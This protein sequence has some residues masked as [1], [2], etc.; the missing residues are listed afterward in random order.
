MASQD[1]YYFQHQLDYGEMT[2]RIP[3][4]LTKEDV[5]DM[6]AHFELIAKQAE[7]RAKPSMEN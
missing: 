2:I 4:K 6:R 5:S 7:R 1:D 3:R